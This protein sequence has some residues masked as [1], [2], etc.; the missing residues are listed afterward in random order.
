MDL[1]AHINSLPDMWQTL[2]A[3]ARPIILYGMGDGADK[4]I[5]ECDRRGIAVSGVFASDDFVRGQ[6]FHDFTVKKY[7]DFVA[8]HGDF[9]VLVSFGTALP[10]VLDN[11]YRIAGEQTLFA[12]DVAVTGGGIFDKKT[13]RERMNEIN[14]V[15]SHLA[16]DLS[17]DTFIN[18][19]SYK[20]TGDVDYLRRCESNDIPLDFCDDETYL[21]LGAYN[22]DTVLEFAAACPIY[23]EII[24][25]E[26]DEK[27]Y[28]KLIRN[29]E[30][31]TRLRTLNAGVSDKTGEAHFAARA[32]RNSSLCD[33]GKTIKVFAVDDLAP[34]SVTFIKAD[35]EGEEAAVIRGAKNT[36][37]HNHPKMKIAAYHRYDDILTIPMQVLAIRPEYKLYLRHRP[38]IP[39]WDTDYYFM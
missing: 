37:A 39:A 22:G 4:I 19:L 14:F 6:R 31:L 1:T 33:V 21:D 15:Y 11:I 29:T 12:P 5:N 30:H 18:I 27:N 38:Q 10:D 3:D 8:E 28:A 20:I 13:A 34:N 9:I 2:A 32:G 24:A 23:R 16:D 25:V 17:R 35:V 7:S 36:I 26:P